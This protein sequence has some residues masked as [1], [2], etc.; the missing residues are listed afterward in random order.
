MIHEIS[1][2]DFLSNLHP[3]IRRLK[4]KFI[5]HSEDFFY[6]TFCRIFDFWQFITFQISYSKKVEGYLDVFKTLYWCLSYICYFNLLIYTFHV[7]T[8]HARDPKR[9]FNYR[10]DGVRWK[11]SLGTSAAR[12]FSVRLALGQILLLLLS[13]FI[14]FSLR[15]LSVRCDARLASAG[16]NAWLPWES[17]VW[18]FRAHSNT[19]PHAPSRVVH[20]VAKRERT[21][22]IA[23]KGRSSPGIP[24]TTTATM[25]IVILEEFS[26]SVR[27][28]G[29]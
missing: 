1:S 15:F 5:M 6:E 12:L 27:F 23:S 2:T 21:W 29:N 11:F 16:G 24:T 9:K 8:R 28:M 25:T 13:A 26:R 3:F 17:A 18:R 14:S 19:Q 22:G 10:T 7:C 4:L 20:T